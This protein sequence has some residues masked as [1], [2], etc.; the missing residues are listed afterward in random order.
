MSGRCFVFIFVVLIVTVR[1][2]LG[3]VF[4]PKTGKTVE[5]VAIEQDSSQL[6]VRPY[7]GDGTTVTFLR[8]DL[9]DVL[10]DS[11]ETADF[12]ALRA[13]SAIKTVLGSS[14]FTELL[15][16]KIPAFESKYR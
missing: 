3:D 9:A 2:S 12:L 13:E 6:I 10:P 1:A 5:G 8:T 7:V 14:P 4:V 11:Q 15:E 16:R